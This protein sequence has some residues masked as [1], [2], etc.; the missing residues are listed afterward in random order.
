VV[1]R[2]GHRVEQQDRAPGAIDQLFQGKHH[3]GQHD[4]ER[5]ARGEQLEHP[6]LAAEQPKAVGVA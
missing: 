2:R 4:V 1:Q 5:R 3:A 6:G